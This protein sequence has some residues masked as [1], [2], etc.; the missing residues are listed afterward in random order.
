[1]TLLE[2]INSRE[3]WSL[4][5]S[6]QLILNETVNPHFGFH[7]EELTGHNSYY[8]WQIPNACFRM[9]STGLWK[10]KWLFFFMYLHADIKLSSSWFL[11]ELLILKW[12]KFMQSCVSS[13]ELWVHWNFE[14]LHL[15]FM[16]L[17]IRRRRQHYRANEENKETLKTSPIEVIDVCL[18]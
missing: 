14:L 1:M 17:R 6:V 13:G 10:S 8:T 3:N 7:L 15:G 2:N 4:L 16:S 5:S 18:G 9:C 12:H 11:S